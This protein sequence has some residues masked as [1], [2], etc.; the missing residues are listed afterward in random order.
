MQRLQDVHSP[1]SI[2][3]FVRLAQRP[4]HVCSDRYC[5]AP[6]G[7]PSAR[8]I[9]TNA[10]SLFGEQPKDGA[11]LREPPP[12][13]FFVPPR[14]CSLAPG[15]PCGNRPPLGTGHP[16]SANHQVQSVTS[17]CPSSSYR[18]ELRTLLK[19]G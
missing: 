11:A 16:L 17:Q 9:P 19:H 7:V 18:P 5:G 2:W 6:I 10:V 3:P 8:S 1:H 14:T 12:P 13:P 4:L 15:Q